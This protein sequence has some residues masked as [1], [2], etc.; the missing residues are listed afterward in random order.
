VGVSP[1]GSFSTTCKQNSRRLEK[2]LGFPETG[3]SG[4][5]GASVRVLGI[6]PQSSGRIDSALK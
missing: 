5:S 3:V 1:L 6:E 2:T 4:G